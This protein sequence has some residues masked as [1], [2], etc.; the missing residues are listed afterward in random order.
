[1]NADPKKKIITETIAIIGNAFKVFFN[2]VN[3]SEMAA[4][5]ANI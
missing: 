5:N 2:P 3:S 4:I 1:M